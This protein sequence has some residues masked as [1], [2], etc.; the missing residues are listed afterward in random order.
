MFTHFEVECDPVFFISYI[1]HHDISFLLN[2]LQ[3]TLNNSE[4]EILSE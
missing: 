4:R 2:V 1:Y 3:H